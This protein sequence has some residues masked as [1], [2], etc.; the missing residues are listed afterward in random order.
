MKILILGAYGQLGTEVSRALDAFGYE[1]AR[2]HRFNLDLERPITPLSLRDVPFDVLVNC[3]A[4]HNVEEIERDDV[5]RDKAYA[6][7]ACAVEQLALTCAERKAHFVHVSTDYVFGGIPPLG[8][9][10][11]FIPNTENMPTA[12]LNNYGRSKVSGEQRI[13]ATWYDGSTIVRVASLFGR[14]NASKGGNFIRTIQRAAAESKPLRVVVDQI[15]S[16]TYAVDSASAIAH[17]VR[18]RIK[19]TVHCTNNGDTSWFGLAAWAL[20]KQ[21]VDLEPCA[22]LDRPTL[23]KRPAWSVLD[24]SLVNHLGHPMRHWTEAVDAYLEETRNA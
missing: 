5:N 1:I 15:M 23:A 18:H 13:K 6:V 17:L 19:G 8:F 2:F 9:N 14:A 11:R 21:Q 7:N 10:G 3:A 20:R 24:T 4:Y 22:T 12:P 16:P